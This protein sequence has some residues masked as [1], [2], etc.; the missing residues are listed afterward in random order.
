MG[1]DKLALRYAIVLI[2]AVMILGTVSAGA[3]LTYYN[4]HPWY[5]NEYELEVNF[6]NLKS[7]SNPRWSYQQNATVGDYVDIKASVFMDGPSGE[8]YKKVFSYAE[9]YGKTN[10]GWKF[11]EKTYTQRDYLWPNAYNYSGISGY[12]TGYTPYYGSYW[13]SY[14]GYYG[15][16]GT[17]YGSNMSFESKYFL[18]EN[19]F[20]VDGRFSEY[21]VIAGIGFEGGAIEAE[22]TAY[23]RVVETQGSGGQ[24]SDSGDGDNGNNG[25]AYDAYTLTTYGN[26]NMLNISTENI[27][28]KE[29]TQ[30]IESFTVKNNSREKF[31]VTSVSVYSESSDF[32]IERFYYDP[33]IYAGGTGKLQ[34]K[35]NSYNVSETESEVAT[36]QITGRFASGKNCYNTAV[37]R[38]Y[39]IV[40]NSIYGSDYEDDDSFTVTD[41]AYFSNNPR[42]EGLNLYTYP[43][44][45]EAG[46]TTYAAFALQNNSTEKFYVDAVSAYD[47]EDGVR[48]EE[49]NWDYSI[50]DGASGEIAVKVTAKPYAED[51]KGTAYLKARGHFLSGKKC[52]YDDIGVERF[53]LE[54]KGAGVET[55]DWGPPYELEEGD[56]GYE[57]SDFAEYVE[58][59]GEF[60][61]AAPQE[62]IIEG[63][64]AV[65][66]TIDNGTN[67]RATVFISGPGL[68]TTP[69][70]ISV[71]A[72]T[73]IA[74]I[75]EIS[76][77]NTQ[78]SFLVFSTNIEG[79]SVAEKGIRIIAL[80]AE[81]AP[82]E[83]I[84]ETNG[85]ENG[86]DEEL[87]AP[88]AGL[89]TALVSLGGG[90]L[91]LG[92]FVLI[93]VLA[94]LTA[95]WLRGRM[96]AV[97]QKKT[98]INKLEELE[99]SG[100]EKLE[101][102]G[103]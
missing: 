52:Y 31:Y 77:E 33:I 4:D 61:I 50:D 56:W 71:P 59:T 74:R 6:V 40:E 95:L 42:C 101:N 80:Q 16:G 27:S 85:L 10:R 47:Y 68:K 7:D 67:K 5:D 65:E 89:G 72:Y 11:L 43:V 41:T 32:K 76:A 69:G 21:K 63:F 70:T 78:E 57:A 102:G 36:V 38:F 34:V 82:E 75:I 64:G 86:E 79:K 49:H 88:F 20:K 87:V 84:E 54:V 25:D 90:S 9:V 26:C 81:E 62:V 44:L 13:N 23:L 92:L 100:A 93:A 28:L 103:I 97:K 15:Y 96:P 18:W 73:E 51:V 2:F 22:E 98:G 29:N 55:P 8:P 37:T 53:N 1:L 35:V 99:L 12:V 19:A 46:S 94:V 24:D 66:I 83:V 17:T 39:V 60:M 3:W 45:I 48:T 30:K 91:I 14:Y 58:T